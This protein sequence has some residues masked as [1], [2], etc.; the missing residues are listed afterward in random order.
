MIQRLVAKRL[1][2][3]KLSFKFSDDKKDGEL[4]A[5]PD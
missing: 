4:G 5:P 1:G 3:L 2:Q